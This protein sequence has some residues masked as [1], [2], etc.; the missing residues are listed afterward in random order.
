LK[1]AKEYWRGEGF[2]MI[3]RRRFL[4][5]GM[6]GAG[7]AGTSGLT[8]TSMIGKQ[9]LAEAPN[10]FDE[11][12][13][14]AKLQYLGIPRSWWNV[15]HG[16]HPFSPER[17]LII[18]KHSVGAAFDDTK[19]RIMERRYE[20]AKSCSEQRLDYALWIMNTLASHYGV[21]SYYE[22]WAT[23][24]VM[25]DTFDNSFGLG[26]HWGV[27]ARFQDQSD[28]QPV[29]TQNG[30]VDWWL[31]LIPEGVDVQRYDGQ[32]T[33]VLFGCV[34]ASGS[35]VREMVCLCYIAEVAKN[36]RDVVALSRMDRFTAA[37]HLNRQLL[38][39]LGQHSL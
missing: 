4:S 34:D 30:L 22:D 20:K 27:V 39:V 8:A 12:W 5:T 2:N 26:N 13:S 14:R 16:L 3:N 11:K 1:V 35:R 15:H 6:I 24:L 33:H 9:E 10:I 7:L 36:L 37:R 31:F 17:V 32:P 25:S 19:A 38:E 28:R 23:R 21:P 18:D 29:Q